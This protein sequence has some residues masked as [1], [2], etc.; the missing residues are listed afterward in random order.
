MRIAGGIG[1]AIGMLAVA[2]ALSACGDDDGEDGVSVRDPG[3]LIDRVPGKPSGLVF[4]D[5]AAVRDKLGAP[6]DAPVSQLGNGDDAIRVSQSAGRAMPWLSAPRRTPL[7]DAIETGAVDAA[8]ANTVF[9]PPG[10]SVIETSQ[11]FEQIAAALEDQGYKRDGDLLKTDLGQQFSYPV[12]AD[13]GDGVIVLGFKRSTVE[14]AVAGS[15]GSDDPARPLLGQVEGVARGGRPVEVNCLR[16]LAVGESFDPDTAELGIQ[17]DGE[18]SADR[19]R[20]P[21]ADLKTPLEYGEPEVDGGVL[22]AEI[23]AGR[24]PDVAGVQIPFDLLVEALDPSRI[25]EC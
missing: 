23:T 21:D 3:A 22:T 6:D 20:L 13:G 7:H 17:V 24:E 16:A 10:I 19:F 8:A 14:D 1:V 5:I 11:P 9:G 25:Y 12:V 15:A 18:A 4:V 2:L